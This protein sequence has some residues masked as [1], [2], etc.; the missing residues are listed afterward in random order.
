M[1]MGIIGYFF[2]D[3]WRYFLL[4]MYIPALLALSYV[5][6]IPESLRW[7][8]TKSRIKEMTKIIKRAA[9]MNKKELSNKTL[10]VLER[11]TENIDKANE[12]K[13][14]PAQEPES[15]PISVVFQSKK[16]LWRVAN[17]SFCWL[18]NTFVYYGLSMNAVNLE[19]N[20]YFNFTFSN[21]IEIPAHLLSLLLV[22]KIGRRWSMCGSLV[23]AGLS[24]VATEFVSTGK[25]R[26]SLLTSSN[27]PFLFQK[28]L[29]SV[30]FSTS[31]ESS[32]FPSPSQS[33]TSTP[34]KCS[35]PT[36]GIVY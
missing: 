12:G 9:K 11:E 17:C 1:L 18:T 5:W 34:L 4:V 23:L 22:N 15:T 28:R 25:R 3:N 31:S 20:K 13:S 33:S 10:E 19:G 8:N 32:L 21:V 2:Q 6:L 29:N 14:G 7:L 26:L 35:P 36:W 27:I 30:S 24:C 16:L